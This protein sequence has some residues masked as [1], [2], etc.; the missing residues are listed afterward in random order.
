[1][2]QVLVLL[3]AISLAGCGHAAGSRFASGTGTAASTSGSPT[4]GSPTSTSSKTP[5]RTAPANL[6]TGPRVLVDTSG[7]GKFFDLPWPLDARRTASGGL[8]FAG[9]PNPL[10]RNFVKE[11]IALVASDTSGA[12]PSGTIYFRFDG[13]VSSP[14]DDPVASVAPDSPV[15]VVNVD[16]ASPSRL[17]RAPVHVTVATGDSVRP[18]NLLQIL[19]VPGRGLRPNT[20]HAAIV[21]RRLGSPGSCFLGQSPAL[22]ELLAGT[23][24]AGPLG[25]DLLA[26]YAP[27]RAAL[28]D[29]GVN[30]DD[31]AAAAVF[32]TGDPT[33]RLVRQVEWANQ[34]PPLAPTTAITVRDQFPGFTAL[35]GEYAPPQFQKGVIPFVLGGGEQAVDSQ[36]LPVTQWVDRA[37]FQ[38]SIPTGKMPAKGFPLYFFVHGTGG[39]QSQFIDRG[40]MPAPNV[41]PPKGSGMASYLAPVGWAAACA[42]GPLSPTRIGFLSAEGYIAYD[43][44]NPVAMRDNF[45]QMILEMVLFRRL[46]LD[47]RIDPALCPGTDASASPDGKIGFDPDTMVVGGQSLGSYLAGMLAALLP[48]WKGCIL[49]G[50]GGSWVEFPFGPLDP[51]MPCKIIDAVAL[52]PGD[53]LDRFHPFVALFDLAL[54]PSDNSHYLEKVLRYPLPGHAIPHVLT[55]EGHGDLQVPEN[56]QRVDILSL[57]LDLAGPEVPNVPFDQMDSPVLPWGGLV[58]LSYP[59]QGNRTVN[60]VVRTA[61]VVRYDRDPIREGHYVSYQLDAP[62]RQIAE[63]VTAIAAGQMPVVK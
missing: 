6:A 17:E 50:A 12:S 11:A 5:P 60:G 47:L 45:G 38:I 23:A 13:P 24:P 55:I 61:C 21:L 62:K 22:T 26:C 27:L 15:Y 18:A 52:P 19:P 57:G 7:Q 4:S 43:F 33:T 29:I 36:G 32:T 10:G 35:Q 48:D 20:V 9:L 1:M 49:T 2:R 3:L 46:L 14:I 25:A 28:N 54:G 56:L 63:F 59:V 42:A 37:G 16:P 40:R 41:Q 30:P 8:G 34:L 44:F 39:D 58:Q 51:V 53:A 31:I